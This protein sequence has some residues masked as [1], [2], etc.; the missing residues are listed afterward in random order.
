[1]QD[2]SAARE[3]MVDGQIRPSD[4]TRPGIADAMLFVPRERFLPASK[5]SVAYADSAIE[6]ARGRALLPPRTF[7]KMLDTADISETDSVLD[8]GCGLGYSTAVL[9]RICRGVVAV[10]CDATMCASAE[11]AL[12]ALDIDNA[13]VVEGALEKGLPDQAPFDV[14]IIEGAITAD[15]DSLYDQLAEGGRLVS[16]WEHTQGQGQAR[17]AVKTNGRISTRWAFDA[18]APVLPGFDATPSFSF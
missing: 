2:Y 6:I 9:A 5:R 8:I 4:V 18:T 12:A 16:I 7:A 11:S 3:A 15:P 13:V 17:I 10:E 14:I 1:M